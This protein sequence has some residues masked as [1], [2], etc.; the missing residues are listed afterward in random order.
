MRRGR[1]MTAKQKKL[2]LLTSVMSVFVMA[3]TILFAGTK[4]SFS[5]LSARGGDSVVEGSITW[6][7]SNST[8]TSHS[9]YNKS[10]LRQTSRGTGVYLYSVGYWAPT[11][12][13]LIDTKTSSNDS[14]LF[15]TSEAGNK[16]ALFAFQ[17]ITKVVVVTG[18][19]TV[20]NAG[21][22]VYVNGLSA[23]ANVQQRSLSA[24]ETYTYTSQVLNGTSLV[25]KPANTYEID[26][27]SVTIEYSCTP[28][29]I[30]S[31]KS[32]SSISVSG[33]TT[34]FTVGDTFSFGGTVTA[35]YSDYSSADVTSSATFSGY[36]MSTTGSQTVTV[37][38][39]EGGVTK[40]TTYSIDVA[41][42]SSEEIIIVGTY[43]YVSRSKY[44]TPDWS[45]HN[46]TITFYSDKTCMW[47]NVR[48]NTLGNSF[49]CK[50]YFTYEA[51]DTG[52][53][54]TL[55]MVHTTYDFTKDGA[56]NN[57]AS[58]FSGGS[59]DR[60]LAGGF[61]GTNIHNDSGVLSS[62]RST[63]TICTYDQS[64]SYEV[65]DTFTFTLAS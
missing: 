54:I 21:F 26:I 36:N 57:Q 55:S 34:S 46:M 6:T 20:S 51:T 40:T 60:P 9:T 15:V 63:L 62:N 2:F 42:S 1:K 48:T 28:G 50:V 11:D 8:K 13:Q 53:S 12:P 59:Y 32:L 18:S 39:T 7:T 44:S 10:F 49:D 29:G 37:S 58:S 43:N 17:N 52:S 41:D 35:N 31:E 47:R 30:P 65:Y 16:N 64:H 56:Y 22:D 24:S 4:M 45:L 33:Q 27:T 23:S 25:I 3:V 14:G 19:R 61:G 38:Y 5:P